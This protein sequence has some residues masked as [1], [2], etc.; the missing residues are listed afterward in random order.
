MLLLLLL[1]LHDLKRHVMVLQTNMNIWTAILNSAA[2]AHSLLHHGRFVITLHPQLFLYALQLLHEEVAPLI[3][4]DLLLHPLAYVG[5]Q[6]AQLDL[7]LQQQQHCIGP[8]HKT[9]LNLDLSM[10]STETS[11][12]QWISEF[13]IVQGGLP[14]GLK[15]RHCGD[16]LGNSSQSWML[17]S[18]TGKHWPWLQIWTLTFPMRIETAWEAVTFVCSLG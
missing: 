8:E 16:V 14:G 18:V 2:E 10:L 17:R 9:L 7:L 6:L 11:I 4:A 15:F 5:L 13:G 1:W 3:L 12:L